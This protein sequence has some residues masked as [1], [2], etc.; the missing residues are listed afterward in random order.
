[1][2]RSLIPA[3][4]LFV[5]AFGTIAAQTQPIYE[6]IG[7]NCSE[8]KKIYGKPQKHDASNKSMECVFYKNKFLRMVFVGNESGIFQAEMNRVFSSKSKAENFFE[9]YLGIA[10]VLRCKIQ[11]YVA[12]GTKLS[13]YKPFF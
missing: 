2:K 6:M 10:E 12:Y 11:T 9:E 5:F 8:V 7:K 3:A 1:M 13:V 4:I